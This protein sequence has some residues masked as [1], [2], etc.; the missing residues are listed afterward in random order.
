M[1]LGF[2]LCYIRN[3]SE[4]VKHKSACCVLC[5]LIPNFELS[6]FSKRYGSQSADVMVDCHFIGRCPPLGMPVLPSLLLYYAVQFTTTSRRVSTSC[7][8]MTPFP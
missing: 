7:Q 1:E 4:S 3:G 6:F 2:I 8:G 5:N